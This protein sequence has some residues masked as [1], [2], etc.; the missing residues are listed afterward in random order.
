LTSGGAAAAFDPNGGPAGAF[1]HEGSW[2]PLPAAPR[3]FATATAAWTGREFVVFANEVHEK[4]P[5]AAGPVFHHWVA[6][7]DPGAAGWRTLPEPPF[8]LA[9]TGVW[10]GRQLV[11]WDQNL[12]AAALDPDGTAG[13]QRLPDVPVNFTDCSPQ[14][15]LLGDTGAPTRA[16]FAEECGRGVLFWPTTGTWAGIEHPRSLAEPPIWTGHDAHFWVGSF[17]GSA[18]GLWLYRPPAGPDVGFVG[19]DGRHRRPVPLGPG[20]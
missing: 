11:A 10:D 9:A 12:H 19:P 7:F 2:R 4:G 16:I 1:E 8:E 15:G 5:A 6:A 14:G 17:A 18:D 13:W 3:R 20:R